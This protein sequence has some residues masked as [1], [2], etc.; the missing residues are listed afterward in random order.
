MVERHK[1]SPFRFTHLPAKLKGSTQILY[2]LNCFFFLNNIPTFYIDM[3]ITDIVLVIIFI[4]FLNKYC[5]LCISF[6]YKRN[7]WKKIFL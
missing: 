1:V 6:S 7:L 2:Y 3:L 4:Y 5:H